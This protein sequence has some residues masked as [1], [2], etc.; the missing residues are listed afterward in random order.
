ME[1]IY[2]YSQL[3]TTYITEKTRNGYEISTSIDEMVDFLEYITKHIK[4]E[5]SA[6]NYYEILEEYI[7]GYDSKIKS[8]SICDEAFKA[9]PK[10]EKNE[11][12]L[13]IPTY[14]LEYENAFLEEITQYILMYLE[15]NSRKR[16][17]DESIELTQ[18]SIDF[19]YK[20]SATLIQIYW[21]KIINTYIKQGKWP[22]QCTDIKE[23]LLDRDLASFI[24]LE[25]LRDKLLHAYSIIAKRISYLSQ[26][27]AEYRMSN[28][29]NLVLA[30]AN[31]D[32]IMDNFQL[33]QTA[34]LEN[35]IQHN[36]IIEIEKRLNRLKITKD[37]YNGLKKGFSLENPQILKLIKDIDGLSKN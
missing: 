30:K 1:K 11:E 26:N 16:Q 2:S 3:I 6:R 22:N 17:I 13:L 15:H 33:Y 29:E 34:F 35:G 36:G 4:I 14:D 9:I 37:Y 12:G 7:N 25:P 20:S 10:V 32:I 27:D 21:N 23:F 31:F 24:K 18:D 5:K 8:W 28:F 19:G